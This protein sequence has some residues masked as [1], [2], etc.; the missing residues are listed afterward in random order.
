MARVLDV[1]AFILVLIIAALLLYALG[2]YMASVTAWVNNGEIGPMPQIVPTSLP[3]PSVSLPH[4]SDMDI[5][6]FD[7]TWII[8]LLSVI[9]LRLSKR[10]EK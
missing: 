3:L 7:L 10:D 6:I 8:I 9:L 1:L 5:I 2:P 4:F